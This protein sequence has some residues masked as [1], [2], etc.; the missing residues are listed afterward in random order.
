MFSNFEAIGADDLWLSIANHFQGNKGI[1]QLGR[2]G[3]THEILHASLTIENP[4]DRWVASRT[5]TINP[6]FAI[7]EVI[8]I[9]CGRQDSQFLNYF[10]NILPRYSGYVSNYHGAYGYRLRK[11]FE[12]DQIRESYEALNH[13]SASRQVVLQI[14]DSKSDLP[15]RDG[16]PRAEDIPCNICSMLKVRN[17]RLE[18]TQVMR[19]NDLFRGLPLNIIQ[20]TILQ[21]VMAGWLNLE[22]GP[23]HH[24]S[25][26]LHIYDADLDSIASLT[27]V[28]T[29]KNSDRFEEKYETTELALVDLERMI[30]NC[31]DESILGGQL[32]ETLN[33]LKISEYWHNMASI[34]IA[35][36]CRRRRDDFNASKALEQ[37]TNPLLVFLFQRWKNRILK[38]V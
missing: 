6:A 28:G 13:N 33:H 15:N 10:N 20:F 9:L 31:I 3:L 17:G 38:N 14:W 29:P 7:A 26:S 12:I 22:V 16:A 36:S 27:K 5:P 11:K 37:C 34:L 4:R 30:V 23:Y 35:E 18:W 25:D 32:I 21:E 2:S 8:W 24:I 19:S 1:A